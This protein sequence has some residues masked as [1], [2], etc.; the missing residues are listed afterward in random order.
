MKLII[1]L[2]LSLAVV[3]SCQNSKQQDEKKKAGDKTGIDS[4]GA[5]KNTGLFSEVDSVDFNSFKQGY[6][7]DG[8]FYGLFHWSAG[9]C[10]ATAL[11]KCA[12]ATFGIGN[13]FKKVDTVN[14]GYEAHL[15]N[16]D[17]VYVSNKT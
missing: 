14:D 6:V 3:M 12:V 17:S 10:A 13:V 15:Y 7:K 1:S 16:G 2:L 11:A 9:N 4:T 5:N 8:F